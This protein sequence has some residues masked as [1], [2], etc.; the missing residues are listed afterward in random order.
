[1][2][3]DRV[4]CVTS[5]PS[6]ASSS[7]SRSW[8]ATR[9]RR[10]ILRMAAWRWVFMAPN[11]PLPG[12]FGPRFMHHPAG[13]HGQKGGRGRQRAVEG[14]KGK[15]REIGLL[16][17]FQRTDL[18]VPRSEERRVGKECRSRWSPYH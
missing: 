6:A 8:L 13:D 4:A 1:M 14:G 2:S 10:T 17:R 11:L 16:T 12:N 7:R 18:A 15:D 5:K 9:S 3:R